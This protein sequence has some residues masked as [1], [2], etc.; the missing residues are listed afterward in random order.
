LPP[1]VTFVPTAISQGSCTEA[2]G[3]V[4]CNLGSIAANA[5]A[6]VTIVVKPTTAGTITNSASV[7]TTEADANPAN[8]LVSENTTATAVNP[9]TLQL[10][11]ATYNIN[12]GGGSALITTTRTDGSD[13]PMSVAYTTT[14]DGSATEGADCSFTGGSFNWTNGDTSNKTFTVAVTNDTDV[15]GKETVNVPL[16]NADGGATLGTPN[17]AILTITDNGQLTARTCAGRIATIV[18]TPGTMFY[19][20]PMART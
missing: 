20:A 11:A 8:N 4:T 1:G 10:S 16:S 7:R 13:S 15:E 18:G 19:R 6:A 2:N 12:E 5:N 17:T 9:G 3:T 14:T